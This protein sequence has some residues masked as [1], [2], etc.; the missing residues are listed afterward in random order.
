MPFTTTAPMRFR[1]RR[2]AER[3][4]AEIVEDG[5]KLAEFRIDQDSD[6]SCIITILE[7]DGSIA[8]QLGA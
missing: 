8:G 5:G 4:L 7:R 2:D 3:A 1:T 6:G